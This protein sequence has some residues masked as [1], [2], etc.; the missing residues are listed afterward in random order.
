MGTIKRAIITAL[1]IVF[2]PM[3]GHALPFLFIG[4]QP[5]VVQ[6]FLG[7]FGGDESS[8][9]VDVIISGRMEVTASFGY[10]DI[11]SHDE[12]GGTFD[13]Y[14][15]MPARIDLYDHVTREFITANDVNTTLRATDVRWSHTAPENYPDRAS[16]PG[17]NFYVIEPMNLTAV[18]EGG[19]SIEIRQLL[20]IGIPEPAV[21]QLVLSCLLLFPFGGRRKRAL[22]VP[23][24]MAEFCHALST[25]M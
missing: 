25:R 16:N 3:T 24:R 2:I 23:S 20:P 6:P 10:I 8:F 14:I 7:E 22:V 18:N 13:F 12:Q 9:L 21:D 1:L 11:R 4:A 19:W 15:L 17:G 5:V